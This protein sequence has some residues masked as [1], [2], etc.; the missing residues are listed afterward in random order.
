M[1]DTLITGTKS[2]LTEQN[3]K[4]WHSA[5]RRRGATISYTD[6]V[7]SLIRSSNTKNGKKKID[8]ILRILNQVQK[9]K[10]QQ[11]KIKKQ[12]DELSSEF[13]NELSSGA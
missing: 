3:I 11:E 2:P 7:I 6:L 1:G 10:E 9:V 5:L 13:V 8:A 12:A 4:D